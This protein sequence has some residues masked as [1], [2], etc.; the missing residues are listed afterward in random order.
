MFNLLLLVGSAYIIIL[1]TL[2]FVEVE[3][4]MLKKKVKELESKLNKLI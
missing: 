4:I 2:S 3:R 1:G